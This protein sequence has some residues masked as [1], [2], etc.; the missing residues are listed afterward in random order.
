MHTSL[1][2]A[3]PAIADDFDVDQALASWVMS[4]YMIT[5]AVMTI[6]IGRGRSGRAAASASAH[7]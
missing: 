6:L 5:G 3:I 2:P 7:S 4:I 1:S